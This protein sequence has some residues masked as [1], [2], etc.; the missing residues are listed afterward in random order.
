MGEKADELLRSFGLST[1]EKKNY[2]R[3]LEAFETKFMGTRNVIC[4]RAMFGLR[5][6]HEGESIE[7]FITALHTLS[8]HCNYGTVR[9]ELVRNRLVISVRDKQLREK[10]MLI[11]NLTLIKAIEIAK[12]WEAIKQQNREL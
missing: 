8:E 12:S 9:E 2:D 7:E 5:N 11:E 10:L 6:Q 4:E 1:T 3:V